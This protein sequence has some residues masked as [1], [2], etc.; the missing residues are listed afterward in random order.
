[1]ASPSSSLHS[2]LFPWPLL[3]LLFRLQQTSLWRRFQMKANRFFVTWM[4]TWER[5]VIVSDIKCWRIFEENRKKFF[6]RNNNHS[7]E[8]LWMHL[9]FFWQQLRSLTS[10]NSSDCTFDNFLPFYKCNCNCNFGKPFSDFDV[11]WTTDY[12]AKNNRRLQCGYNLIRPTC[13]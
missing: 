6:S 5:I 2:S 3:G 10:A 8:W 13:N 7:F 4:R 1:M 9:F 11:D 12:T